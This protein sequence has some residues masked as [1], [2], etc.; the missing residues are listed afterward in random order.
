MGN[1][2]SW[3]TGDGIDGGH[4]LALA[5]SGTQIHPDDVATVKKALEPAFRELE[6]W[7]GVRLSLRPDL[8]SASVVLIGRQAMTHAGS[9]RTPFT[10]VE[11]AAALLLAS[12]MIY[13]LDEQSI[14]AVEV[15]N[16]VRVLIF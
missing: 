11:F 8:L 5:P 16:M 14:I 12:D 3:F 13:S 4:A 7:H 6:Q 10:L 9:T 2:Q 15:L 1:S